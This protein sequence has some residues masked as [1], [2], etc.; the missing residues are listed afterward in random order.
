MLL[1]VGYF[2][3]AFHLSVHTES[4]L[5]NQRRRF[6]LVLAV[7]LKL[8]EVQCG[9]PTLSLHISTT[10]PLSSTYVVYTHIRGEAP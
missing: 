10:A 7:L 3:V 2:Y 6:Q 1:H 8:T 5:R 4:L 9:L